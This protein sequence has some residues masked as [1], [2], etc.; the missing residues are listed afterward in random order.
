[1]W[2]LKV[3]QNLQD[4]PQGIFDSFQT[5]TDLVFFNSVHRRPPESD[6]THNP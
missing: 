6:A 4:A 1:M 3:A 5:A 2:M